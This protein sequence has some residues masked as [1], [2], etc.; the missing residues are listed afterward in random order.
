MSET[1][2]SPGMMP[3]W[4]VAD[5]PQPPAW[6]FRNVLA[7][8]GPGTIALSVSIGTGEWI[9]GPQVVVKHGLNM[10]WIVTIAILL[11]L[12]CN[13]QFIRYTVYTGEPAINGFMRLKPGPVFWGFIYILFALCQLGWPAWAASSA[14]PLYAAFAGHLPDDS[15]TVRIKSSNPEE[16]TVTPQALILTPQ[17]AL[18][19]HTVTLTGVDDATKDGDVP[20]KIT[21]E[22]ARSA[23]PEYD[24]LAAGAIDILSVSRAAPGITVTRTSGISV[25]EADVKEEE[26]RR[27]ATF[28]V[29]L[30]TKPSA[31]VT[32][33]LSSSD[34]GEGTVTPST[35]T[36]TPDNAADGLEVRVSGVDDDELDG[37][38][39]FRVVLA[40]AKSD[41]AAYDGMDPPDVSAVNRDDEKGKVIVSAG[42]GLVT[43]EGGGT[44][45]FT[46]VLAETPSTPVTIGLSS[47]DPNEGAVEPATLTF[48]PADWNNPQTVTVKGVDDKRDDERASYSIVTAPAKSGDANFNGFDPPD[49]PVINNSGDAAVVVAAAEGLRVTEAGGTAVFTVRLNTVPKKAPKTRTIVLILG[50]MNFLIAVTIIAFGGK[51]ERMLEIVNWVMVIFIFGYLLFVCLFFVRAETWWNGLTGFLGFTENGGWEFIPEGVNWIVLGGFA[52]FAAN[53]GIGNVMTSNWVRDKGYGMGS[54]VGYISSAI[55]GKTV[56]VS[57]IG[58]VFPTTPENMSKWRTWWKYVRCDQ[59]VVWAFGCFLG[60]YLNCIVA[61][62]VIPR[63]TELQGLAAGAYQADY[64]RE[65][66][67]P[68]VAFM[69]LLNGFWIL[70]GSQ[71]VLTDGFVRLATDIL[72]GG[73]KKIRDIA[74]GDIR[75]IYYTF[76]IIFAVWGCIA[77]NIGRPH[78]LILIA[79]NSAGFILMFASIHILILNRKMLPAAVQAP[80]WQKAAAGCTAL[81]YGFFLV[82]N[83]INLFQGVRGGGGH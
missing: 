80:W 44:D 55:G 7:V 82:M 27:G 16:V 19:S 61:A 83:I 49:V 10:M 8:V 9:L 73:S 57:P 69:A 66:G 62:E 81:F 36:L 58:T 32:I 70:L 35:L 33:A 60:M 54:L 1:P 78:T 42:S 37:D 34:P 47:S 53:G 38:Q 21:F 28:R 65:V 64:L 48:T 76:I 74:K 46:V 50:F 12:A 45:T 30:H 51:V 15:V 41:D 18:K 17:N 72:W 56:K 71:I 3:P 79:S 63:G 77:I 29:I 67:G 23:D 25:S 22:A 40:P 11:Q 14:A 6:N 31:D 52:A 24:G 75:R 20:V 13:M 2:K 39:A 4:N 59:V 43:T 68:I 5:I 26:Q